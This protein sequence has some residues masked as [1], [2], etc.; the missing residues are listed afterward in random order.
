[1]F[2]FVLTVFRQETLPDKRYAVAYAALFCVAVAM[3]LRGIPYWLGLIVIA[4][5]CWY[6]IAGHCWAWTGDCW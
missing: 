6:W 5:R 1:M 3:V 2:Q 4:R